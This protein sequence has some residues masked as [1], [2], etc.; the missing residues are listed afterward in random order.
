MN[1]PTLYTALLASLLSMGCHGQTA[2]ETVTTTTSYTTVVDDDKDGFSVADDCDD[3][4]NRLKEIVY[5]YINLIFVPG[6]YRGSIIFRRKIENEP[7]KNVLR[8]K[9][10][11]IS[12]KL[13]VI[14]RTK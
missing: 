13:W 8:I 12:K 1:K 2:Q 4:D 5:D 10:G 11:S 6:R 14:N 7:G 9:Y 3:N